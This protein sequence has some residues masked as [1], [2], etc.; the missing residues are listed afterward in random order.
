MFFC[1]FIWRI[2]INLLSLQRFVESLNLVLC[3]ESQENQAEQAS[4][5]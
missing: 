2:E 4:I 5:M 1:Y 3:Q